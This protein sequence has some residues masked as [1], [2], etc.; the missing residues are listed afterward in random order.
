MGLLRKTEL[1]QRRQVRR[2]KLIQRRPFAPAPIG[3]SSCRRTYCPTSAPTLRPVS[4]SNRK[5]IRR[6][7]VRR[8]DPWQGRQGRDVTVLPPPRP[9]PAPIGASSCRR[10]YSPTSA[11]PLGPVSLSNGRWIPPYR[12][13]ANRKSPRLNSGHRT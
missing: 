12:R 4:L 5:W 10:T 6:G 7:H 13:L 8:P 11:P 9:A 2:V 1:S 3:S